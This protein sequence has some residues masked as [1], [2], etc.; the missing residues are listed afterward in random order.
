MLG[1]LVNASLFRALEEHARVMQQ[2]PRT[3]L[4]SDRRKEEILVHFKNEIFAQIG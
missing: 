2:M 3:L 4:A 1:I